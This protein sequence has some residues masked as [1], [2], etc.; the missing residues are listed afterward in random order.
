MI[1]EYAQLLSTAHR[2]LDGVE[3]IEKKYVLGSLPARWRKCKVW[4]LND[5]RDSILYKA[6][7]M[8]HPSAVW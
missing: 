5:D 1:L 7:H 4:K 3:I 8:N 6:T 2:V